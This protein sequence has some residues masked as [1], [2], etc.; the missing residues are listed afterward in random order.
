[1]FGTN[2]PV[3]QVLFKYPA[4]NYTIEGVFADIP[5]QAHFNAEVLLSFHDDMNLPPPA[6][7]QWGETGFYTY[8]KLTKDVDVS[9][10]EEGLNSL[11][12]ENKG[13]YF[14]LNKVQHKYHLQPITGIHLYSSLKD[15][16]QPNSRAEYVYLILIV[17]LLILVASGFNYIQFSFSRLIHS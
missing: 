15:E 14:E 1:Y 10:I 17:G 7:A 12:R 4:Y 8:L 11:A 5:L 16:L 2:N 9:Q 6:K 13:N 3:G